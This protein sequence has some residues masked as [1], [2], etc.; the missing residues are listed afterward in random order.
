M[1]AANAY[2]HTHMHAHGAALTPHPQA[3]LKAEQP[4]SSRVPPGFEALQSECQAK[5]EGIAHGGIALQP[6]IQGTGSLSGASA[7]SGATATAAGAVAGGSGTAHSA[8]HTAPSYAQI[9]GGGINSAG[10]AGSGT[11]TVPASWPP[12]PASHSD[13]HGSGRAAHTE[14][15][16]G[17]CSSCSSGALSLAVVPSALPPPPGQTELPTCPVCLERLDVHISGI[18]TTVCNHVFHSDCLQRWGDTSCPV[19]R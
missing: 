7:T 16:A 6:D 14:G 2:P 5:G 11:T 17:A 13:G 10:G 19:C 3:A 4:A 1:S 9:A 12:D 15:Q 18:I 8:A